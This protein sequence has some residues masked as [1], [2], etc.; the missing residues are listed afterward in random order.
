MIRLS[1]RQSSVDWIQTELATRYPGARVYQREWQSPARPVGV[2]DLGNATSVTLEAHFPVRDPG[3]YDVSAIISTNKRTLTYQPA[4][5]VS[6]Y[7][8]DTSIIR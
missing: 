5:P 4:Q 6:A 7:L 1:L 8:I 3:Y 2:Y